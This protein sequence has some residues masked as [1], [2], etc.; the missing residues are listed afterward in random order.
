MKRLILSFTSI[1]LC[2]VFSSSEAARSSADGAQRTN[3]QQSY[4]GLKFS[5]VGLTRVREH[6]GAKAAPGSELVLVSTIID[7]SGFK[8]DFRGNECRL[9]RAKLFDA[10]DDVYNSSEQQRRVDRQLRDEYGRVYGDAKITYDWTFE[11][12]TGK[13]LKTFKFVFADEHVFTGG[14][15]QDENV[16]SLSFD[17]AELEGN[18]SRS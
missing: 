7:R 9:D 16:T 3:K 4:R 18:R 14:V 2:L 1:C 13:R 15:D 5:V 8:S 6:D 17:L 11:V 12:P 10:E